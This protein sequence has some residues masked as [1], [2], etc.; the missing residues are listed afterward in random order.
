M[1]KNSESVEKSHLKKFILG[2]SKVTFYWIN[3]WAMENFLDVAP[4]ILTRSYRSDRIVLKNNRSSISLRIIRNLPS[5]DGRGSLVY[6]GLKKHIF[7]PI[8]AFQ[9]IQE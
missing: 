7:F 4:G 8:N 5:G 1:S 3:V 2:Q 9:K 6:K